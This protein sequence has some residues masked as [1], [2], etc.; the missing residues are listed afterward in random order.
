[1]RSN[2][3]ILESYGYMLHYE[4]NNI[5]SLPKQYR[6][7]LCSYDNSLSLIMK[8]RLAGVGDTEE[9]SLD[10][11]YTILYDTMNSAVSDIESGFKP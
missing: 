6:C 7:S 11:L 8:F 5:H 10:K 2:R 9:E 1:M 4:N 3:E